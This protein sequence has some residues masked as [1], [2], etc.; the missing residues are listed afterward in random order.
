M[1]PSEETAEALFRQGFNCAQAVFSA[2]ASQLGLE[3]KTALKLASPFGGGVARRGQI[4]G[5]VSGA[6]MA[7]GLEHGAETPAGKE[8]IY[9]QSQEL[10]RRFEEKHGSILCRDLIGC[11]L[12]TPAGRQEAADK[13]VSRSICPG[14]VK[15]AA[16]IAREM[17]AEA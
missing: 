17:L 1:I 16:R 9:R 12:S 2:F 6:L 13:G 15:E 4:C 7:F 5:A 8:E 11:D 3:D 10:L 14:L